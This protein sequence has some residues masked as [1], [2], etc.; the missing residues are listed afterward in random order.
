MK[1]AIHCGPHS[2]PDAGLHVFCCGTTKPRQS[3]G[4]CVA[5]DRYLV[6]EATRA[7]LRWWQCA[8]VLICAPRSSLSAALRATSSALDRLPGC[9]LAIASFGGSGCV[10]RTREGTVVASKAT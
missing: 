1:S 8:D 6:V 10:L 9:S 4:P 3:A 7:D 5:T 2:D